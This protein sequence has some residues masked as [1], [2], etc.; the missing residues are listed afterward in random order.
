[1]NVVNLAGP[2]ITLRLDYEGVIHGASLSNALSGEDVTGWVGKAWVATVAD[3]AGMKVRRMVEDAVR[4]NVS[5]FRQVTQRFPSGRELLVE[6][7]TVRL[8]DGAGLIAVGKSLHAVTELQSRLLATQHEMEREYWK[9]RELESRYR[10]LFDNSSEAVIL[11]R[12]ASLRVVE[13]NPAAA[14]ALDIVPGR[15]PDV[16]ER[17]FLD[18][19]SPTERDSLLALLETVRE[20]G[21]APGILTHLGRNAT[22]WLLRASLITADTGLL[23]LLQLTPG[24]LNSPRASDPALSLEVAIRS[25]ADPFVVVDGQGTIVYANPAFVRRVG[26]GSMQ[27]VIGSGLEEWFPHGA[28]VMSHV[29][30]AAVASEATPIGPMALLARTGPASILDLVVL[31]PQEAD[32]RSVGILFTSG[33]RPSQDSPGTTE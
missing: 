22:P 19:V 30:Q 5:A 27:E 25:A 29:L 11:V 33:A 2:D 28:D 26:T 15:G 31:R 16:A 32:T 17:E 13:V 12:A 3:E 6:Y 9:L 7:T 21:K 14:K 20:H 23:F 8:G 18:L 1:M 24:G 4:R 10:L